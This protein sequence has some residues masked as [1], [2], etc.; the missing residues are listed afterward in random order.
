MYTKLIQGGGGS[1]NRILGQTLYRFLDSFK[2]HFGVRPRERFLDPPI[3]FEHD[4]FFS[5]N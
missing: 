1:K 5:E 4:H 3:N 2:K